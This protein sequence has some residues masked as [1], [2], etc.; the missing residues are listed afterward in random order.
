MIKKWVSFLVMFLATFALFFFTSDGKDIWEYIFLSLVSAIIS[1]LL[2][3]SKFVS[4]L[5]ERA[6]RRFTQKR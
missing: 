3:D 6:V 2:A 4:R 1:T 5:I